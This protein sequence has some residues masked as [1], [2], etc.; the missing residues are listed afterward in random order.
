MLQQTVLAE[1]ELLQAIKKTETEL[2]FSLNNYDYDSPKHITLQP[3][4]DEALVKEVFVKINAALAEAQ[5]QEK[6]VRDK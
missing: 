6:E 5:G 2:K 1:Y 3:I 4:V